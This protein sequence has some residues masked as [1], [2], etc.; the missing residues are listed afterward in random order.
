MSRRARRGCGSCMIMRASSRALRV[1]AVPVATLARVARGWTTG[2]RRLATIHRMIHPT[3]SHWRR[4]AT[5][6]T[7]WSNSGLRRR[8]PLPWDWPWRCCRR[9]P[10]LP[11][12]RRVTQRSSITIHR[13][14]PA[15]ITAPFSLPASVAAVGR[16]GM[17]KKHRS[18]RVHGRV[19]VQVDLS[20]Y[21]LGDVGAKLHP[22]VVRCSTSPRLIQEWVR[23]FKCQIADHVYRIRVAHLSKLRI[24][25]RVNR[26]AGA[27]VKRPADQTLQLFQLSSEV[28]GWTEAHQQNDNRR[29]KNITG[30]SARAR[31]GQSQRTKA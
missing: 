16:F 19:S 20:R 23:R 7:R 21:K 30:A 31:R 25:C 24:C 9:P 5:L 4:E 14:T 11:R 10:F 27:A 28:H 17:W 2:R 6:R 8:R 3:F 13:A 18:V 1:I 22:R 15:S 26:V 29:S 12:W